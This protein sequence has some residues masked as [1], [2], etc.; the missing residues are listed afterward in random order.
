MQMSKTIVT[1]LAATFV[2]GLILTTPS[3]AEDTAARA[4]ATYADIEATLGG[5]PTFIRQFPKAGVAGAWEELKALEFGET[6]LPAKTKALIGVAV[7]AQIPCTYCIWADTNSAKAAGA[8]EEEI[9]EAVAIAA[10]TRHWSTF[11][12]GMQVDFDTFKQ[13]LGGEVAATAQ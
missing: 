12:H 5:V 1:G 8:T 4:E 7:S 13:E 6:A 9:A 2:A 3:H 10:L 11:L